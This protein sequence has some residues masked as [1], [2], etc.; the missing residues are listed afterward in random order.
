[1]SAASSTKQKS[2]CFSQRRESTK[3]LWMYLCVCVTYFFCDNI[4]IWM[5][6]I[7]G[8]SIKPEQNFFSVFKSY[9]CSK[10]NKFSFKKFLKLFIELGRD[11][12]SL[13]I[14]IH[15]CCRPNNRCLML[16]GNCANDQNVEF[17]LKF[18]ACGVQPHSVVQRRVCCSPVDSWHTL[19]H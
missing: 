16:N 6:N 11:T 4:H 14:W 15:W 10:M 18:I 5:K 19:L 3:G 9:D 7:M 2:I 12:M 1:M 13:M 17:V 8:L